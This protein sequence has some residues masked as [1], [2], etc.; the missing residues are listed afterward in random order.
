MKATE[1]YSL[2]FNAYGLPYPKF[3]HT[4]CRLHMGIIERISEVERTPPPLAG[5]LTLYRRLDGHL[6]NTG[7]FFTAFYRKPIFVGTAVSTFKRYSN[8]YVI[9]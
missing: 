8:E 2:A 5:H 6:K 7:V 9:F 3:V 4:L 1:T